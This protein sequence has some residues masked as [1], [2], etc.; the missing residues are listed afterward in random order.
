MRLSDTVPWLP[1][2]LPFFL[3]ISCSGAFLFLCLQGHK[4]FLLQRLLCHQSYSTP[5]SSPRY[6]FSSVEVWLQLSWLQSY[7]V[8]FRNKEQTSVIV[9]VLMSFSAGS[10]IHGTPGA[11]L[12]EQPDWLFSSLCPELLLCT[13]GD[14]RVDA[15]HH[16]CPLRHVGHFCILTDPLE[17]CNVTNFLEAI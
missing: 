10:N 6:R 16:H 9:T 12:P 14:L 5:L 17:L 7:I 4:S 11:V 8:T 2:P 3:W 13:P 15:G 1:R